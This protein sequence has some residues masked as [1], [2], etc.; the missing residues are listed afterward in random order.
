MEGVVRMPETAFLDGTIERLS[1]GLP[2]WRACELDSRIALLRS[3]RH[4][5]G[6][7]AEAIVSAAN[8]AQGYAQDQ[9]WLGHQWWALYP[10]L[11]QVMALEHV[12]KRVAAGKDPVPDKAVHTRDDG[13]VVVDVFP[14][15]VTDSAL[16]APWQYR[17]QVW[18][19][20]GTS[21]EE[22]MTAAAREYRGAGFPDAGVAVVLA[23]GNT[24][25][26]PFLDT[27]HM[28]Y[29]LG[30]VVLVKL[31]P[32]NDYLLPHF[33]RIFADFVEHG[34]VRFVT[35][36][37][38]AGEYLANHPGVDRLHMTGS[39]A[40]H[41]AIV[42]G[43]GAQAEQ[44]RAAGTPLVGKPFTSELG[45]VNP[46]IVV[47]GPWKHAD[48]MHH[49][50]RIV[51]A[52]LFNCGHICASPQVVIVP[53]GWG[54]GDDLVDE[55]RRLLAASPPGTPYYPG[56]DAKIARIIADQ[57]HAEV[58]QGE[59]RRVLIPDADPS[60]SCSLFTHEV[61]ADALGI[62]RLPAPD[63]E[64]YLAAATAFAND[65]LPGDLC[66][67]FSVAPRTRREHPAALDKAL[68]ELRYGAIGVNE[69]GG[70][71]SGLGTT[72]WGGYPGN[73]PEN[74][75]SGTGVIGNAFMLKDVEK[76]VLTAAFRPVVKPV[77]A[78]SHRTLAGLMRGLFLARAEDDPRT[79]P[80]ALV[81]TVRG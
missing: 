69:W 61:F 11:G 1:A 3:L 9:P 77:G 16:F 56:T 12:L 54:Y 63:V 20:S 62:V 39:A 79:V 24:P 76:S 13:R 29:Q 17:A 51:G 67:T 58:L 40:V 36:G 5:L 28:L 38:D 55:I 66:A 60:T 2:T 57:P 15:G 52:K 50:D 10:A 78:A 59:N 26:G 68:V 41:D 19:R 6:H 4:R 70:L 48:V 7:E 31:N 47:P 43:R 27:V 14:P 21:R 35:G 65:R 64:K 75:G 25:S 44:A 46:W 72:T 23:A 8:T 49:A 18:L 71:N 80:A 34:W 33:E 45:G 53:A 74:I 22:A 73:T 30:S 32:V 81:A 42:W 37:A